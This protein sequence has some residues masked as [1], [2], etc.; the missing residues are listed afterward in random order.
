MMD[1]QQIIDVPVIMVD[2]R[3]VSVWKCDMIGDCKW[4]M[5]GGWCSVKTLDEYFSND[6][7]RD[8][9]GRARLVPCDW[10]IREV[11]PYV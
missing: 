4:V 7:D 3:V 8:M 2:D 9:G 10:W 1:Q 5:K 11:V 6:D